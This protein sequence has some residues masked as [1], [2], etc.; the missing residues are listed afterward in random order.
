MTNKLLNPAEAGHV[1]WVCRDRIIEWDRDGSLVPTRRMGPQGRRQ[2]DLATLA[3]FSVKMWG[4]DMTARPPQP[5]SSPC[6]R[7]S[8]LIWPADKTR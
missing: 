7:P 4:T 1:F 6:C 3:A 5:T 8:P 2:Y